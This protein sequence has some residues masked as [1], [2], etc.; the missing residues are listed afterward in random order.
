MWK[1]GSGK[2]FFANTKWK[3]KLL[4]AGFSGAVLFY[5][6]KAISED[7]KPKAVIHLGLCTVD[8]A[9]VKDGAAGRNFAFEISAP[10]RNFLFAVGSAAER[11][12]WIDVIRGEIKAAMLAVQARAKMETPASSKVSSSSSSS[13]GT[14]VMGDDGATTVDSASEKLSNLSVKSS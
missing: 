14:S 3:E 9:D 5:D 2:G 7:N 1:Q 13:V 11:D 6:D 12:A 4:S 10:Q 8:P